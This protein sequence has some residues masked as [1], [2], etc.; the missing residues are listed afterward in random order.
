[1]V[2]HRSE[3]QGHS[4]ELIL[5]PTLGEHFRFSFG[6]SLIRSRSGISTCRRS[7]ASFP[8]AQKSEGGFGTVL[9]G[10]DSS[11]DRPGGPHIKA[12]CFC[13]NA[14]ATGLR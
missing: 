6:H 9:L 11:F 2:P 7:A 8:F 1:M 12:Q 13:P 10:R 14:S 3:I 5:A 4:Y